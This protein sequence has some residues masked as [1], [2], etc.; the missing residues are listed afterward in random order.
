[1]TASHFDTNIV[2][3]LHGAIVAYD[4]ATFTLSHVLGSTRANS[5]VAFPELLRS[6]PW[7]ILLTHTYTHT[8]CS[9]KQISA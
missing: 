5:S 9:S 1:M 7:K 4:F 8:W 6:V 3:F 2:V